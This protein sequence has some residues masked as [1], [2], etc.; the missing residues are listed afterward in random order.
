MDLIF[1]GGAQRSG[2]T[3][4]QTLIAG[5]L[6]NAP[7]L[8]EAHLLCDVFQAHARAVQE[9]S[10]TEHYYAERQ[11]LISFTRDTAQ[12]YLSNLRSRYGQDVTLVLKDPDFAKAPWVIGEV[13]PESGFILCVRDPRDV[14][15]S[16]L[17]IGQRELAL[18]NKEDPFARRDIDSICRMIKISFKYFLDNTDSQ[19]TTELR[20]EALVQNPES[21]LGRIGQE[22]GLEFDLD[23]VR[24]PKWLDAGSRHKQT[25]TSSLE[26][27]AVSRDSVG[28]FRSIMTAREIDRVQDR[29]RHVM[30]R[31]GYEKEEIPV[32]FREKLESLTRKLSL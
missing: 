17:K 32:G 19:N 28:S 6:P 13:L 11:G 25:W 9:W 3:L 23:G 2:T 26:E 27:G 31:F 22:L 8:P 10:K 14:A 12:R 30:D 21:E 4:A 18:G 16:F 5:C 15:A 24:R 1:I 29:C 20:Y 7:I